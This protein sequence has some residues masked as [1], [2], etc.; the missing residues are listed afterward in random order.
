MLV[1]LTR[2]CWP[3][4]QCHTLY[5][6]DLGT[7]ISSVNTCASLYRFY[8]LGVVL[9]SHVLQ[10]HTQKGHVSG[11]LQALIVVHDVLF[12]HRATAREGLAR[13]ISVDGVMNAPSS[14]YFQL[15]LFIT[16]G[17]KLLMVPSKAFKIPHTVVACPS[18]QE[19]CFPTC[20][21]ANEGNLGSPHCDFSVY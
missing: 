3:E 1:Y 15:C 10:M 20:K 21:N 11:K 17:L 13:L 9:M 8:Y 4:D 7:Q 14:H 2:R 5:G 16:H 12:L 19:V 6:L 18:P